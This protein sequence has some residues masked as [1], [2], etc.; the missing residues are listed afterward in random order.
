MRDQDLAYPPRGL[1]R[2]AAARYVGVGTTKFDEWVERR[3]LPKGKLVDGIR[4][5]DRWALDD[6][7]P[8]L[9]DAEE[10]SPDLAPNA[11]GPLTNWA[12]IK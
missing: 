6:A 5:W 10:D 11:D 7:F 1:R 12:A 8:N 3:L 4:L 2:D 9:P